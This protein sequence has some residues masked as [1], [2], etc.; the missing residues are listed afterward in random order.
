M[1][2]ISAMNTTSTTSSTNSQKI[3]NDMLGKDDFLKLLITELTNQDPL[4]PVDN[5]DSIAQLAQFSSLE[6]MNNL[7]T[8]V[9]GLQTSMT[10]FMQQSLLSQG[11][12]LIGK[13]VT[14]K[15]TDGITDISGI[16]DSVKWL[17]GNPQLSLLQ[18]DGTF[19]TL[20]MNQI[21]YVSEPTLSS[22]SATTT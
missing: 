10:S 18:A 1:S 15:E 21:T 14:G 9:A 2:T 12:A 19:K 16:V 20:E 13:Q 3:S 6:Q 11:S 7:A 5:K 4:Q 8:T 22:T 17:D